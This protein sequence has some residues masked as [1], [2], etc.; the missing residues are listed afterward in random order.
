M[1]VQ[2][3]RILVDG[4][5]RRRPLLISLSALGTVTALLGGVGI[6]ADAFDRSTTG[7]NSI[8]TSAYEELDLQMA[9]V[10]ADGQCGTF[11]DDLAT[12]VITMESGEETALA[13]VCLRNIGE[14][15][16]SVRMGLLDL[17]D[18]DPACS[19]EEGTID[20]TCGG[21]Q[22]GELSEVATTAASGCRTDPY[23]FAT[24]ALTF[25]ALASGGTEL[26]DL[27]AG[28][29]LVVCL[30][31]SSITDDPLQRRLSQ[32]D[33]L[34]WRYAFDISVTDTCEDD[35]FEGEEPRL[36]G[37]EPQ[38]GVICA[39]DSDVFTY[40]HRGG[41]LVVDLAFDPTAGDL[42]L[43]VVGPDGHQGSSVETEAPE[44][45]VLSSAPAGDYTIDV[46][47]YL[48]VGTPYPN[49]RNTYELSAS[50]SALP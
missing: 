35:A 11:S 24:G 12:G 48:D 33:R 9:A 8:E 21:D 23:G 6:F 29:T 41:D 45:V 32:T 1:R 49:L 14:R 43:R 34:T 42:D 3:P 10:D 38:A 31:A 47:G 18:S 16:G 30:G 36:L 40:R 13:D 46:V 25:D 50:S 44:Q 20:P 22:Q 37:D 7:Q 39:N 26:A 4:A 5:R 27:A 17:V 15:S 28:E 19:G 2:E